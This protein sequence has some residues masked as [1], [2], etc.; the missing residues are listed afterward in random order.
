MQCL[1]SLDISVCEWK[2]S[3]DI[4]VCF[5]VRRTSVCE[6]FCGC[7]G[8][9]LYPLGRATFP[10]SPPSAREWRNSRRTP[11]RKEPGSRED[12][13]GREPVQPGSTPPPPPPSPTVAPKDIESGF[14]TPRKRGK[15]R[16]SSD[17][18]NS[19]GE[20]KLSNSA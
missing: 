20:S 11:S 12:S 9:K 3:L 8:D 15:R 19:E 10:S 7:W 6:R 2:C 14:M 13:L 18:S 16:L 1:C 17:S 4:S 5:C